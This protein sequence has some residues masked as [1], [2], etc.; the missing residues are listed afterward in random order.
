[1]VSAY[2]LTMGASSQKVRGEL[3]ACVRSYDRD[4][5]TY[6]RSIR[7]LLRSNRQAFYSGAIE[8]LKSADESRGAQYLIS[9]LADA[10]LLLPAISDPTLTKGEAVGLAQAALQ[11]GVMADV[12]VAKHLMELAPVLENSACPPEVQ[13]LVDVLAEISDGARALPCLMSLARQK[14]PYLQSKAVLMIGRLNRNVKWVQSR[15]AEPDPRV[16]ANAVE[17]LW[18]IDTEEARKLLRSA[19]RDSNNRVAGNALLGLYRMGD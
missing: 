14:N 18:G 10:K 5:A 12:L 19:S 6:G 4:A 13:R 9:V 1:Y 2:G 15:L 8:I 17:A 11:S 3:D 16:R 7:E